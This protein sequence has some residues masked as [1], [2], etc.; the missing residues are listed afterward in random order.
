MMGNVCRAGE[1]PKSSE[2]KSLLLSSIPEVP[3]R[4]QSHS[5]LSPGLVILI[6]GVVV[7]VV[8]IVVV[9]ICRRCFKQSRESPP[10]WHIP[11]LSAMN[12]DHHSAIIEHLVCAGLSAK[13]STQWPLTESSP[14]SHEVPHF[15]DKDTKH[16]G[17]SVIGSLIHFTNI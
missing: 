6:V 2:P 7:I 4:E 15:T 13:P 10:L 9:L 16:Q 14:Q 12:E 3:S 17:V 1:N 11:G 5:A 8:L